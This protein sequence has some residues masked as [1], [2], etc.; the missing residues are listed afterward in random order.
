MVTS[1]A[2]EFGDTYS[3]FRHTSEIGKLVYRISAGYENRE[4]SDDAGAGD[5]ISGNPAVTAIPSVGFAAYNARDFIRNW[6]LRALPARGKLRITHRQCVCTSSRSWYGT[7][8][9][10]PGGHVWMSELVRAVAHLDYDTAIVSYR[11]LWMYHFLWSLVVVGGT[12]TCL[13]AR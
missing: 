5:F 13:K 2:N 7:L 1:T 11:S 4:S 12:G 3:H 10:C 9:C 8:A 6:R